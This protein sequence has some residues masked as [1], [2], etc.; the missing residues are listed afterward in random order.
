[1]ATNENIR[2]RNFYSGSESQLPYLVKQYSTFQLPHPPSIPGLINGVLV[3][4]EIENRL[5]HLAMLVD[6]ATDA[7]QAKEIFKYFFTVEAVL[8]SMRRV[9]DDLVMS[10]YCRSRSEEIARTRR[11]EVDGYGML[12]RSGR[13][14]A[15]GAEIIREY[16]R[17]NEEIAE[18]LIELSNSYK[19][20]YLLPEARAWGADVP[21]VLAIH[22]HRN[23]YSKSIT[24]HNHSL[25][26]LVIGFNSL[27]Q[28]IVQ[29]SRKHNVSENGDKDAI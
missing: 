11:I 23:D 3:A 12:F 18:I 13:P 26:Q 8:L 25:G 2:E 22:A 7:Y 9:I 17:P 19:H 6:A 4:V 28:R 15:F 24:I 20:S 1:M 14:T 29:N 21:T 16:I 10:L 27:I 5:R